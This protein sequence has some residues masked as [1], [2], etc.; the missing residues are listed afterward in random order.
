MLSLFSFFTKRL[1]L[2]GQ[3][4][5]YG[6]HLIATDRTLKGIL[7]MLDAEMRPYTEKSLT[8]LGQ[9]LIGWG[10]TANMVTLL[11]AALAVPAFMALMFQAYPV[12]LA[13]IFLNRLCDGLDGVIA[14]SSK[15]GPTDFGGFLDVLLDFIF[16]SGVIF[17]FA[18][19]QPDTLF[20]AA[21]LIFSLT[22]TSTSFLA[23]AAIAE[24][25]GIKSEKR[26]KKSFFH[27]GGLMEGT[28]T[29]LFLITICLMPNAFV[30]LALIFSLLCWITTFGR[31]N[32]AYRNFTTEKKTEEK[33]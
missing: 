26:G 31:A 33:P 11:G 17:F 8:R 15:T 6:P 3:G 10:F 14:R 16:Y 32:E 29:I 24:K 23:Y 13:F 27:A 12:A 5:I 20:A 2:I 21:F 9:Y 28:E 4:V 7:T 25:R 30:P 1:Y 22:G 18:L 19:G